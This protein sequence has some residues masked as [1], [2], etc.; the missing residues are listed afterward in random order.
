MLSSSPQHTPY[1]FGEEPSSCPEEQKR[2][3]SFLALLQH[4]RFSELF[5]LFAHVCDKRIIVSPSLRVTI[6]FSEPQ[7]PLEQYV[8]TVT[9]DPCWGKAPASQENTSVLRNSHLTQL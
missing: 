1:C 9:S 2:Q 3:L 8:S 6:A 5:D 7:K 4:V